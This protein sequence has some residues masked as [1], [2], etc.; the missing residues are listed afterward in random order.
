MV[1]STVGSCASASLASNSSVNGSPPF[2]RGG[3]TTGLLINGMTPSSATP[4]TVAVCAA[5]PASSFA[6]AL[7]SDV[8][9]SLS[10]TVYVHV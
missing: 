1:R 5:F 3:A 4:V 2:A 10:F 8:T 9:W 7:K 6:S